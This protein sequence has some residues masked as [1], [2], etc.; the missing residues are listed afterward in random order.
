MAG[1]LAL[2][3]L[4]G[5]YV[6]AGVGIIAAMVV[7]TVRLRPD[8]LLLARARGAGPPRRHGCGDTAA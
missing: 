1:W 3:P 4:T 8:P 2:P 6:I 7:M 5:A